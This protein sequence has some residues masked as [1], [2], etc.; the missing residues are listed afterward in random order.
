M[1]A[2]LFDSLV[3]VREHRDGRPHLGLGLYIVSLI[4]KFHGGRAE[5]RDLPDG[6]GVAF[7]VIFPRAR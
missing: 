4:A 7:S 3:S 1:R 6:T 2:Q 5:A